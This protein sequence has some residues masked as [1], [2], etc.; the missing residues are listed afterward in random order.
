V[1]LIFGESALKKKS[2]NDAGFPAESPRG[3]RLAG[4]M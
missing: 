3:E 2:L 4:G 1:T